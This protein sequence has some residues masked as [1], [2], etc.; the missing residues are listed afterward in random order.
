VLE[1]GSR[2]RRQRA[3]DQK[4]G[5]EV[6]LSGVLTPRFASHAQPARLWKSVFLQIIRSWFGDPPQK[7]SPGAG[8]LGAR[9]PPRLL[10]AIKTSLRELLD[11]IR[12]YVTLP[13]LTDS[14]YRFIAA[15]IIKMNLFVVDCG[16]CMHREKIGGILT[17]SYQKGSIVCVVQEFSTCC[18]QRNM[19]RLEAVSS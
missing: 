18:M 7:W 15:E 19:L 16:E 3:S 12:N 11:M 4:K 13:L 1:A 14:L 6:L 10:T 9:A 8:F 2:E 5:G 17:G